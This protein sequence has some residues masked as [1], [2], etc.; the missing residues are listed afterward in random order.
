MLMMRCGV[1][2]RALQSAG[3]DPDRVI[4]EIEEIIGLDCSNIIRASAKMGLGISEVLEAIVERIPPPRN[5]V[6]VRTTRAPV[7]LQGDRHTQS[8]AC[9]WWLAC[10][11]A[12]CC[13]S[14]LCCCMPSVLSVS[15]HPTVP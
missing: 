6:Q 14:S 10:C 13:A 12:V 7:H 8:L 3:A 5:T 15:P 2:V 11:C 1:C 9:G 4:R